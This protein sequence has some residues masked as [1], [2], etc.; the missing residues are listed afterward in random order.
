[1]ASRTLKKPALSR[2]KGKS[3][4][5][6]DQSV[7]PK[8][9]GSVAGKRV[10]MKR[11]RLAAFAVGVVAVV[12]TVV[13][14]RRFFTSVPE[15]LSMAGESLP[16]KQVD[17]ETDGSLPLNWLERRLEIEADANLLSVDLSAMKDRLESIGQV[18]SAEIERRFPDSLH[19]SIVE[20]NP[21]TRLLAQESDGGKLLLFVDEHGSVFEGVRMARSLARSLP[22]LR[23]VALRR[24]GDRFSEIEEM[25]PVSKLLMEARAIAPHIYQTW[26]VITPEKNGTVKV[27][28]QQGVDIVFSLQDDL[29]SQLA[30][31][32][33]ITDYYR[34]R[35]FKRMSYV[36]LTLGDQVPVKSLHASR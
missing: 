10:W 7:K 29:R 16:I 22:Y 23:G 14:M 26:R 13:Q 32:D 18:K 33:Y 17:I 5:D 15:L 1:M 28:N 24:V 11:L 30:K 36:D 2:G 19:V 3:W 4:K 21:V 12:V 35:S 20:R 31:L 34:G 25:V 9:R 27:K 8:N 6:L